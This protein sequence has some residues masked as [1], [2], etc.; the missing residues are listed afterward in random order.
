L[1]IATASLTLEVGRIEDLLDDKL[2]TDFT[3]WTN[4]NTS[5]IISMINASAD[6]IIFRT[7]R[8]QILP[9][10]G[11]GNFSL[12]TNGNMSCSGGN[13]GGWTIT[14]TTLTAGTGINSVGMSPNTNGFSFWAGADA[15]VVGTQPPFSVMRDGYIRATRGNIANLKM[16]NGGLFSDNFRLQTSIEDGR[17]VS[18]FTF[19]NS[20]GNPSTVITNEHLTVSNIFTNNLS[21]VQL[22]TGSMTIYGTV[23]QSSGGASI[24]LNAGDTLVRFTPSFSVGTQ[25]R[26]VVTI[27]VAAPLI[28]A[29][30]FTFQYRAGALGSWRTINITIAAGQRTG[31][32]TASLAAS[33]MTNRSILNGGTFSQSQGGAGVAIN[34][35]LIWNGRSVAIGVGNSLIVQ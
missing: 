28:Q 5:G 26:A 12:D 33:N 10:I 4:A 19:F 22:D 14:P 6:M 7:N 17:V 23:I 35:N 27:S 11:G 20:A 31:T 25:A 8:F 16:E 9:P 18:D 13:V 24:N 2:D 21:V 1:Q 34:G 29:K 3:N 30:T 32:G 15:R